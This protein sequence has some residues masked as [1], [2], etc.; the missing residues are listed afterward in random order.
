MILDNT[1]WRSGLHCEQYGT[2]DLPVI[3]SATVKSNMRGGASLVVFA[4]GDA[5]PSIIDSVVFTGTRPN[6]L[7]V[8]DDKSLTAFS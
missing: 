8:K 2:N 4:T 1:R 3:I 6:I 7:H 5:I